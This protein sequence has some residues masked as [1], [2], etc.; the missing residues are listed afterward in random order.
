MKNKVNDPS[1]NSLEQ[2]ARSAEAVAA[3]TK[4]LEKAALLA[5]T[6][7]GCRTTTWRVLLVTLPASDSL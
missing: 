5:N 4:K 7:S 2:F 6:F 1:P 3:T